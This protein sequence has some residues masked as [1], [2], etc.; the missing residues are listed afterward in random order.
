MLPPMPWFNLVAM[1]DDD[2]K[3]IYRYIVSLGPT[4]ETMPVA[5]APG[6]APKTPYI[7]FVPQTIAPVQVSAN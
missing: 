5:V 7:E 2:L 1:S 4:G 3:S 6:V